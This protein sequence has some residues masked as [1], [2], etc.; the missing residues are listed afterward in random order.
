MKYL[1]KLK[2][3]LVKGNYKNPIKGQVSGPEQIYDVFKA[4]KDYAQETLLGVYLTHDLEV[5]LYDVLSVGGEGTTSLSVMDVFGRA[6]ISRSRYI[7]LIH[8]HPKGDPHPSPADQEAMRKLMGQAKTLEVGFL[9][10]I[11]VGDGSYWSMFD[12]AEGGDYELGAVDI[13]ELRKEI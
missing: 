5:I 4:I 2:I 1:R 8:N 12:A 7:V 10:F 3:Q 11:I 13:E 6:F 9:D